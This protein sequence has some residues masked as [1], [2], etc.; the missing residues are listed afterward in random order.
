MASKY[1]FGRSS[2]YGPAK[3]AMDERRGAA[4]GDAGLSRALRGA[5]FSAA[6]G[7]AGG[8]SVEVGPFRVEAREVVHHILVL[9]QPPA[10]REHEVVAEFR[11]HLRRL[12]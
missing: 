8:S 11:E 7:G 5:G 12:C 9:L 10:D 1:Y 4:G 3:G 2:S 6:F